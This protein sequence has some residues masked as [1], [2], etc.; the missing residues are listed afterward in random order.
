MTTAPS[1]RQTLVDHAMRLLAAGEH[2]PSLRAVARAAGVSAMAPY[3]HFP[4][5]TALLRAVAAE[6]FGTLHGLLV[7]ADERGSAVAPEQA[8]VEQGLAYVGFAQA[9][10]AL[11]RLM[12]TD[13]IAAAAHVSPDR[14]AEGDAY[15]VLAARVATLC[16]DT[17]ATATMA[18]WALVHGFATLALDRR[19][20][21]EPEAAR[22]ALALF[23][24]GLTKKGPEA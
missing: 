15:G 12:F 8:L 1:L 22:A 24:A 4:D 5:K 14:A 9:H 16:P 6:G 17:A 21:P 2:D 11:F 18:A 13:A 10:P 19:L 7:A 3:R 20:P 23:V